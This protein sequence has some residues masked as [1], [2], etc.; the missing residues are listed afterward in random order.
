MEDYSFQ[1]ERA[2]ISSILN[3]AIIDGSLIKNPRPPCIMEKIYNKKSNKIIK[4]NLNIINMALLNIFTKKIKFKNLHV[5]LSIAKL[6]RRTDAKRR[7]MKNKY[8]KENMAY[9]G[10]NFFNKDNTLYCHY[11]ELLDIEPEYLQK[12]T[13]LYFNKL[14]NVL[15]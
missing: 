14:D 2:F 3:Q 13:L 11:C 6:V 4:N 10:R 5:M 1:G 12:K 8:D 15:M 9:N 7:R